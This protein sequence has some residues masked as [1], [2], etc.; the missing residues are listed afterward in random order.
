MAGIIGAANSTF[1]SSHKF[2]PYESPSFM[3]NTMLQLPDACSPGEDYQCKSRLFMV[4]HNLPKKE[5]SK[6][7]LVTPSSES[8][9]LSTQ[10]STHEN[11]ATMDQKHCSLRSA[12][13]Y[14]TELTSRTLPQR[15]LSRPNMDN[16]SVSIDATGGRLAL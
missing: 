16:A 12:S 1:S 14:T 10:V 7:L 8:E 5:A 9:V 6:R 3:I 13:I 2:M 11:L 15:I 4:K